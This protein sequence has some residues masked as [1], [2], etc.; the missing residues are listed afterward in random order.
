M[1]EKKIKIHKDKCRGCG[2]CIKDC[3]ALNLV[4]RNGK[5]EVLKDC[6]LCGHCYAVCPFDAVEMPGEYLAEDSQ[7]CEGEIPAL[8]PKIFLHSVKSRRSIRD[9]KDKPVEQ[10]KLE[11]ILQAGRYT[12]TAKNNQDCSFAFVQKERAHLKKVVWDFIDQKKHTWGKEIPRDMLPYFAF[13]QRRKADPSDDYLFRNAPVIVFIA[14]NWP[15]DAGLAAQNMEMMA[16]AEGLGVLHNGYLARIVEE[17]EE[18]KK[19]LGMEGKPVKACMLMGYPAV[20]YVK[21]APR[22][23]PQVVWR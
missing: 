7:K 8:D 1:D 9:Y 17:N 19:W 21:T 13:N 4:L 5:A 16:V 12:A 2:K 22:K 14:S 6:L 23:A 3:L 20:K 15:L 11:R 10:E 18:V